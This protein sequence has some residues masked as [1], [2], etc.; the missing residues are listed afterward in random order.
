MRIKVG[1]GI[2][3]HDLDRS[4]T[5]VVA[6][7]ENHGGGCADWKEI[8][9]TGKVDLYFSLSSEVYVDVVMDRKELAE[10]IGLL[11]K[12]AQT[13]PP[14]SAAPDFCLRT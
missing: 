4:V 3:K 1:N 7:T 5:S 11:Q 8:S 14:D 2:R 6:V 10:L 12:L 13:A 9:E